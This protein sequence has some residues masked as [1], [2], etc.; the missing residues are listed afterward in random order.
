MTDIKAAYKATVIAYGKHHLA[1][2]ECIDA[3]QKAYNKQTDMLGKIGASDE[4]AFAY[5]EV[6]LEYDR[7]GAL[8]QPLYEKREESKKVLVKARAALQELTLAA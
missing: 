3:T 4:D 1:W 2:A 6:V 5:A 8:Q 7:L